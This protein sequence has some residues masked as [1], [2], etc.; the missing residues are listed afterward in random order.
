MEIEN[1]TIDTGVD[2]LSIIRAL[3]ELDEM[4]KDETEDKKEIEK[5]YNKIYLNNL[6]LDLMSERSYR[7]PKSKIAVH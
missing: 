5:E 6:E 7:P 3:E 4:I 2:K 1:E